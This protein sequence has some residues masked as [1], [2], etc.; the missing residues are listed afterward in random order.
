V[1]FSVS[2]S[3]FKATLGDSYT[4]GGRAGYMV[5]AALPYVLLGWTRA[6]ATWSTPVPVTGLPSSFTGYTV[7]GGIEIPINRHLTLAS[8]VRWTQFSSESIGA[9]HI[10]LT[11]TELS[12]MLRLNVAIGSLLDDAPRGHPFK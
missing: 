8:E 1:A 6:D 10:D 7:G 12:G 3:L 5:G 11:P 4:V 9:S 2:P